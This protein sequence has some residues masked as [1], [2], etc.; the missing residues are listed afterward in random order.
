MRSHKRPTAPGRDPWLGAGSGERAQ[1]CATATAPPV[2]GRE[3]QEP[4]EVS[5]I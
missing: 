2:G 3:F 5:G 4:L 1:I